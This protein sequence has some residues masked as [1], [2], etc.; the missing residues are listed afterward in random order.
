MVME[1][2]KLDMSVMDVVVWALAIV[3]FVTVLPT[4]LP[5]YIIGRITGKVK[6]PFE[7]YHFFQCSI[8]MTFW[9]SFAMGILLWVN[10]IILAFAGTGVLGV[11][12]KVDKMWFTWAWVNGVKATKQGEAIMSVFTGGDGGN[13]KGGFK[14]NTGQTGNL[15]VELRNI[16]RLRESAY[17]QAP[18]IPV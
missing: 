15:V 3:G 10:P 2:L 1:I 12:Q 5:Q 9:F 4:Y 18:N 13:G 8:C 11:W 14:E 16:E 17:Y 6:E 7:F